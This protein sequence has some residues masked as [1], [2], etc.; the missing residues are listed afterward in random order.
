[1]QV[2]ISLLFSLLLFSFRRLLFSLRQLIYLTK[3][4]KKSKREK[5][6][7]KME[8]SLSLLFL[9]HHR[10]FHHHCLIFAS[11]NNYTVLPVSLAL[12]HSQ[13]EQGIQS[14]LICWLRKRMLSWQYPVE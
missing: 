11:L 14:I 3:T 9:L 1:M 12:I 6:K 2:E 8:N 13:C 4:T 10:A 5:K 7:E